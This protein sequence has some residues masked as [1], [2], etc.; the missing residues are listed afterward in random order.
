MRFETTT[1]SIS[2]A[3]NGLGVAIASWPFIREDV[4]AGRLVVPIEKVL[5]LERAF[6]FW[7]TEACEE[8]PGPKKFK[9]WLLAQAA[10]EPGPPARF[11]AFRTAGYVT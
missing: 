11:S 1:M 6:Q 10:A 7:P 4:E 2:A 5:L 8:A 3:L 9:D